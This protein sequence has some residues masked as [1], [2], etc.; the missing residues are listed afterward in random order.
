MNIRNLNWG[1]R[2]AVVAA[3]LIV[4]VA[5]AVVTAIDS[6]HPGRARSSSSPGPQPAVTTSHSAPHTEREW[7]TGAGTFSDPHSAS[8][9]GSKI[10][11]G[12]YVLVSCKLYDPSIA[13]I[14]PGG[15]WYRIAS[16][17]WNNKYYAA[18]NT[19]LNGDPWGGPY[20]HP[21]DLDV[22]NC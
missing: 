12:Q 2:T 22:P 6:I 17:P 10:A 9:P 21:T 16:K 20:T 19:F 8:G 13:S 14:K 5:V 15:Y 7:H 11:P 1:G 18:A 3:C 4:F